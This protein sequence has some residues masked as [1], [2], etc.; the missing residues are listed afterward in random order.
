MYIY[1]YIYA[2]YTYIYIYIYIYIYVILLHRVE[3]D[4]LVGLPPP[5]EQRR[6][7]LAAAQPSCNPLRYYSGLCDIIV[8]DTRL[9]WTIPDY[10]GL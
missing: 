7:R 6:D 9:Y 10:A 4:A 5:H 2:S 1:I 3:E 8:D